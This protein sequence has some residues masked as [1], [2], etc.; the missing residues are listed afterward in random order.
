MTAATSRELPGDPR[1]GLDDVPRV[2]GGRG[3]RVG[4]K[5]EGT[6]WR[7]AADAATVRAPVPAAGRRLS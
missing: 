2:V 1:T 6:T 7:P 5:R 3:W 4:E